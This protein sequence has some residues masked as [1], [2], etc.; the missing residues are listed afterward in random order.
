MTGLTPK[1]LFRSPQRCACMCYLKAGCAS[2][3]LCS[4]CVCAELRML[5]QD[6]VC[7]GIHAAC[8]S[9]DVAAEPCLTVH[10]CCMQDTT[11]YCR[12]C[13]PVRDRHHHQYGLL[14]ATAFTIIIAVVP[15]LVVLGSLSLCLYLFQRHSRNKQLLPPMITFSELKLS[16]ESDVLFQGT[17]G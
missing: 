5:Q 7:L 2:A 13:R 11:C 16:A 8:S 4:V 17:Y 6:L 9:T 15:A 14:G 1:S 10:M 12:P 3:G